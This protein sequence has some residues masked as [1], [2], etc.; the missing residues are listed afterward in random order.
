MTA[1]E[2]TEFDAEVTP[3]IVERTLLAT[4][5]HVPRPRRE[6]VRRER[7]IERLHAANDAPVT[8]I[9]APAGF[10]KTT[11]LAEW[12]LTADAGA[13]TVAWLALDDSD[14][15]PDAFWTYVI[16]A[17]RRSAPD[18]AA[19]ALTALQ[20]AQPRTTVVAALVNDLQDHPGRVVLVLDDYHAI[21]SSEVHDSIAFLIDHAPLSLRLVL[22][23]RSDPPLPLAR[24]RVRGQLV[25]IRV[26]D[27]R[28]THD[29]SAAYLNG[30]MGL[31]LADRDVDS[32]GARTE[33]WI[34]ALQLAALSMQG[35]DDVDRFIA[36][37]AG[38]D[39]FV[40]DYLVE[41]VLDRQ[42]EA[43][44]RFLL[45]TSVL[46]R[47]TGS[48]CDAVTQTTGGRATLEHL[49]RSNLFLVALDDRRYWYRYHQL[50]ADV[51]RA[52]LS[53]EDP[54]IVD[55]L[56]RRASEWYAEHGE[57]AAAVEHAMAGRHYGDAARLIELAAPA[58]RRARQEGT[59]RRWLEALPEDIFGD[60][61]VLAIALVGA[62]MATGD[63]ADVEPLL[64]L[65]EAALARPA[66]ASIVFDGEM[67]DGLPAQVAVQR[68][69]LTLLA[70][71]LDATI[72]HA[73]RALG[74][75]DATD[76]FRR[77]AA[78]A[79][80][81]LARWTAGDLD[82]A[83]RCYTD[84]ISGFVAAG[85]LPDMLGC[86]L[87]LADIQIAQGKLSDAKNTFD[88]G[89]QTT[90]DHPG[91]RG[92]ADMHVGLSEVLI[93]RNEL[94]AAAHHL[95]IGEELGESAGL[96][97]HA[98]RWRVVMAR[99]CRAQGDLGRALE[100]IDEAA[101]RYDTDF[102][103]PVRPVAAIRARVQLGNGD[104]ASARAWAAA[105]GL[106][107]ADELTY[108]R[109]YEHITLARVLIA[110]PRV[111]GASTIDDAIGLLDRLLAAALAGSRT[112]SAIEILILLAAGHQARGDEEAAITALEDALARAE[113]DGHVRLFLHAG[114]GVTALLRTVTSRRLANPHA[115]RVLA[116]L[117]GTT[118]DAS[119]PAAR[120]AALVDPLSRRELD[121][122]RLLRT[123]LS[124]P[125]IARELHVSLNTLRTH[126]KNIFTKLDATSRREALRRA[127]E[128]GL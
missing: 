125:D 11:L 48:L 46:D 77:S 101:P 82:E 73:T 13:S 30:T 64:E 75:V 43:I 7:L 70:G 83:V 42:A 57:P 76:H 3:P 92:A 58:M 56:H 111:D 127:A 95:A 74:L 71:D 53:D 22:A 49:D 115:R 105:S 47:L 32:L 35:R 128:L 87:A 29:E 55:E 78:T 27:L 68:A 119:P 6:A 9:S 62:R 15:D 25:E 28:F 89:L 38:D 121:V 59:L 112:G 124:G 123:D 98:Y 90:I 12:L 114:P 104:V 109:E 100:L 45:E 61:P 23:S 2:A 117:D 85:Y 52:R 44:R 10:G 4:K 66:E 60:R 116:A 122:L 8:L 110:S 1:G 24:L 19:S 14:N 34:A 91:L 97:Q 54:A 33:G 108:V 21:H 126:T 26:G 41:E 103:P 36:N 86:S 31:Q 106:T 120:P 81:A 18:L 17:I 72:A 96:P 50:F 67:F 113:P 94:A 99:L 65:I 63:I 88:T 69:G 20:S 37:F 40:V 51:L 79:L 39:R 102:S 5:L 93:E 16:A 118:V 84:A 107:P 80:L